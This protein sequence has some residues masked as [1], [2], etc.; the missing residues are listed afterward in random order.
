MVRRCFYVE[1]QTEQ[2]YVTRAMLAHMAGFGVQGMGT[3]AALR[4]V[5]GGTSA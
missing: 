3:A 2:S 1:G 4:L 5:E